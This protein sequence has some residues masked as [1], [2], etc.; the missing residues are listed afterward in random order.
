MRQLQVIPEARFGL[1]DAIVAK[2]AALARKNR[3]TFRRSAP[4][5]KN[6]ARWNHLRYPGWVKL[7]RGAGGEVQIEVRPKRGGSEW[8]L[9]QAVLGFVDRHFGKRVRAIHILYKA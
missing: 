1:Y 9:L 7:R 2:Q 4:K 8:Q 5:A 6:R 3:G